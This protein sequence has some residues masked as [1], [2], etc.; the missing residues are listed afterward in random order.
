MNPRTCPMDNMPRLCTY[1]AWFARPT[2]THRKT[3]FRLAL[4]NK[5][6]QALLRFRLGCHNLPRDVGSRTAV[7]RSQRFCTV[8]HVG[9]PGDE[10]HRCLNVR[11]CSISET[12]TLGCLTIAQRFSSCGRQICMGLPDS[13]QI[14]WAYIFG[15]K[16]G[17]RGGAKLL[18]RSK[19]GGV[20]HL[21][22]PRWLEEM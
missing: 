1:H 10:Y 20:R 8:C 18:G 3:I 4:S 21:I 22:S 11:A 17:E 5:C 19:P 7:P 14:V 6:V 2:T 13:S 16:Q 12:G 15:G 9:Q